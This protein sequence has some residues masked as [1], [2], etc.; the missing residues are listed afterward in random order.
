MTDRTRSP[1][2]VVGH[3]NEMYSCRRLRHLDTREGKECLIC[4]YTAGHRR[5]PYAIV[6]LSKD[7]SYVLTRLHVALLAPSRPL[8]RAPPRAHV[9]TRYHRGYYTIQLLCI[10]IH[11]GEY[12]HMHSFLS[13][14]P[15]DVPIDTT[16]S[17]AQTSRFVLPL[18]CNCVIL[19][20]TYAA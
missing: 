5:T 10:C 13:I 14:F 17:C 6:R 1:Y 11:M 7:C 8:Q 15:I 18:C 19:Q 20:L 3:N 9:Y 16:T 12:K 4:G 2:C